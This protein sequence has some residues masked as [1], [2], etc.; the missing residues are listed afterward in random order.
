MLYLKNFEKYS[1][2]IPKVRL[3]L[4]Y[5][6]N[7]LR[8]NKGIFIYVNIFSLLNEFIHIK[9]LGK[10]KHKKVGLA[11]D[12]RIDTRKCL[13]FYKTFN[14]VELKASSKL[15]LDIFWYS[16][17]ACSARPARFSSENLI[18]FSRLHVNMKYNFCLKIL[19]RHYVFFNSAK[20]F[21]TFISASV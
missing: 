6:Y 14:K 9:T 15:F 16:D 3:P 1:V 5:F 10:T 7:H 11:L 17:I 2:I 8:R 18:I 20:T 12:F 21:K 4:F 13:E 19:Y